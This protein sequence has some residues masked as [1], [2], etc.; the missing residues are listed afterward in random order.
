MLLCLCSLLKSHKYLY[1]YFFSLSKSIL[2]GICPA[3]KPQIHLTIIPVYNFF[4]SF[5]SFFFCTVPLKSSLL[6]RS[7]IK[8]LLLKKY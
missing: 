6:T 3:S 7:F 5:F 2:F 8:P 4:I 1:W